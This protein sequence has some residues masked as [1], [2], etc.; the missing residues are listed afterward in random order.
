MIVI[1]KSDV[2]ETIHMFGDVA[3]RLLK[4]MGYEK[5][6]QGLRSFSLSRYLRPMSYLP[7]R[8]HTDQGGV[9]MLR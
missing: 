5:T 4:I 8:H 1:F 7:I 3:M 2:Y 6:H 9:M